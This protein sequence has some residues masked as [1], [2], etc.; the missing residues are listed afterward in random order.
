MTD[1]NARASKNILIFTPS[2]RLKAAGQERS[3]D[4][5]REGKVIPWPVR[6]LDKGAG[7]TITNV[8]IV[9]EDQVYAEELRGLLEED[10]KHRAYVIER[11]S[12]AIDGLVVLDETTL[13]HRALAEGKAAL[14]YVVLRRES[15]DPDKL[16][17]TGIRCV[18]PAEYSPNLVRTVILGA[19]LRLRNGGPCE[20]TG[21]PSDS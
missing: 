17:E 4:F 18:V 8:Q 13:H 3:V 10:N 14:R 1:N 11:P 5:A 2:R 9:I 19:E 21:A 6:G 7:P 12:P 20:P 16:W 15:F